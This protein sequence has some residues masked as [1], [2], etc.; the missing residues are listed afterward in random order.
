M[1]LVPLLP[2]TVSAPA[3]VMA[4]D[5][6]MLPPLVLKMTGPLAVLSAPDKVKVPALAWIV[7]PPAPPMVKERLEESAEPV[8]IKVAADALPKVI[9]P[10]PAAP[11]EL[12]APKL[13]SLAALTVPELIVVAPVYVLAVLLNVKMPVPLMV[14]PPVLP[15]M[16]PDSERL[17]AP[18]KVRRLL[19]LAIP[20]VKAS[21]LPVLA[22]MV[23]G[24]VKLIALLT[25]SVPDEPDS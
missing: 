20:P 14:K 5:S 12:L 22:P 25:V 6:A 11:S 16:T 13:A 23:A 2:C 24:P 4:P 21:V 10:D 18:L 19:P 7:P 3:P 1:L 15:L 9:A 17:P 8:S